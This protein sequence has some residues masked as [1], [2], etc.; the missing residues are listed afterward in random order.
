MPDHR[1][2]QEASRTLDE[3]HALGN[4]SSLQGPCRPMNCQSC[5]VGSSRCLG[6]VLSPRI[7]G[8]ALL[9]GSGYGIPLDLVVRGRAGTPCGW[10]MSVSFRH[11]RDPQRLE[12]SVERALRGI[13]RRASPTHAVLAVSRRESPLVPRM[14]EIAEKALVARG[15]PVQVRSLSENRVLLVGRTR[16]AA[17][18]VAHAL[19]RMFTVPIRAPTGLL[20]DPRRYGEPAW[21]ALGLALWGLAQDAPSAATALL[22]ENAPFHQ[23]IPFLAPSYASLHATHPSPPRR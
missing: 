5:Q 17:G 9:G 1:A 21:N 11:S 10:V 13:L 12:R 2:S 14:R 23:H 22:P 15:I 4:V 7:G 8:I 16:S 3:S 6:I 18:A 20:W 19:G